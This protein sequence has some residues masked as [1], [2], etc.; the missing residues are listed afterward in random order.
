MKLNPSTQLG[1]AFSIEMQN[2]I[3]DAHNQELNNGNH[4][5]TDEEK[6]SAVIQYKDLFSEHANNLYVFQEPALN[7]ADRI[8][9]DKGKL[10]DFSF[11]SS[12]KDK[13]ITYL[14]DKHCFYRWKKY[15][16]KIFVCCIKTIPQG[17]DYWANYW[18]FKIDTLTGDL[19]FPP[20]RI[21]QDFQDMMMRFV[22][23][24]IFTE[25][26]E[27]EIVMLK[28]NGRFG[29]RKSGKFV[30]ESKHNITIIDST[31]NKLI[32]R[33]EGFS[34]SG[35]LRLQRYGEGRKE[36]KLIFIEE[37]EKHGYIRRARKEIATEI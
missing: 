35:H 17:N 12:V 28:P 11:L 23:L 14:I 5:Y 25:L 15:N 8:K 29:T 6:A 36:V 34:V 10:E 7:I 32:I 9:L 21:D 30:N 1:L 22:K 16:G 31:W 27:L 20:D 26:S 37:F 2:E 19:I 13:K 24:L 3:I 18:T 33:T 4:Q